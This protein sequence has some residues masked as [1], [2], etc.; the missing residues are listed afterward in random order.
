MTYF[1]PRTREGC[2]LARFSCRRL[3]FYFNPRTREGCDYGR[4]RYP[5]F[6]PLISIHAPVKGATR[7]SVQCAAA[8]LFDFNPRTREGCDLSSSASGW[9]LRHFNPRTREGCDLEDTEDGGRAPLFQSTH[10]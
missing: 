1:N 10:P 3:L 5:L 8:A 2:D 4:E 7:Q 9:I 6:H